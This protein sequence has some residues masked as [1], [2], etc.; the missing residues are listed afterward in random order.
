MKKNCI[1]KFILFCLPLLLAFLGACSAKDGGTSATT[2]LHRPDAMDSAI[3]HTPTIQAAKGLRVFP[4]ELSGKISYDSRN[5]T[6]MSSR[7]SG[8]IERLAIKYNYQRVHK[9][10]L[11]F[12]I[13]SPELL[14]AQQELLLL[15]NSKETAL[16]Q[17]AMQKL[18]YLGM[19]PQQ[20]QDILKTGKVRYRIPVYCHANGYI[21]ETGTIA[22]QA[23]DNSPIRLQ[24][25]QYVHAGTPLFSIYTNTDLIAE[26]TFPSQWAQ[27]VNVG[28]KL[29]FQGI[30]Q[31]DKNNIGTIA[32]VQPSFKAGEN[33]G[34]ARVYLKGID[35][36]VGQLL[37]GL[38]AC[39]AQEGFWV[40]RQAVVQLGDKAV[41]F[42]QENDS[43]QALPVQ[44]GITTPEAV[45]ILSNIEDWKLAKHAAYLVDS[46]DFI[47]TTQIQGDE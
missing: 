31:A 41:V 3:R 12:E 11:L 26:F 21:L 8:R 13:Y 47:R 34:I 43:F 20:V 28:K 10:Q 9:G 15:H 38:V 22:D 45:Q 39:T 24:E 27:Q 32:L 33:F 14:S 35:F 5:N 7:V 2:A 17:A 40:P 19:R 1:N 37:K 46:E 18:Q 29:L 16:L 23:T 25:G 42:K 6:S 4:L 30:D 44:T 36:P